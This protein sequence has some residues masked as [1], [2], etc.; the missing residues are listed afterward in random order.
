VLVWTATRGGEEPEVAELTG[1]TSGGEKITVFVRDG[2]VIAAETRT[3]TWCPRL[4]TPYSWRWVPGDGRITPFKRSGARFSV[5]RHIHVGEGRSR[6]NVVS[7]L[8]GE[9]RDD[10]TE[11]RG[12]IWARGIWGEPPSATV[13]SGRASFSARLR[14]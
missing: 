12:T 13:C 4:A 10:G 11:V 6:S 9:L 5:R 3:T 2:E 1:R 8:R 14:G 7:V